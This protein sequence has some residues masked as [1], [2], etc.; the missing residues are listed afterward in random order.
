VLPFSAS[1][2][3]EWV[4][5]H[6]ARHPAPPSERVTA[7][8]DT[9]SAIVS[10]LLAKD[11]ENR[12]QTAA[13]GESDLR[14]CLSEW[15]SLGR[16]EP[17]ARRHALQ[18]VQLSALHRAYLCDSERQGSGVDQSVQELELVELNQG[19]AQRNHKHV[20][21][22]PRAM[23]RDISNRQIASHQNLLRVRT[24]ATSMAL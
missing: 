6:I 10:K 13:G 23:D 22:D 2:P 11:A 5:C 4:H 1:D 19:A 7:I 14:H 15:D 24:K 9:I 16:G 8:P 17:F 18:L 21:R 12:Y 3:M 20:R